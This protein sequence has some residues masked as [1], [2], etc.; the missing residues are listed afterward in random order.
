M[1]DMFTKFSDSLTLSCIGCAISRYPI[2]N[3]Y[4]KQSRHRIILSKVLLESTFN[5]VLYGIIYLANGRPGIFF[6]VS[7]RRVPFSM[8]FFYI[9]GINFEI[10]PSNV[11]CQ[12]VDVRGAL[13]ADLA[14]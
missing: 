8:T 4:K 10:S 14:F 3:R 2:S 13:G 1:V 6:T 7:I 5:E 12:M 11:L 9:W